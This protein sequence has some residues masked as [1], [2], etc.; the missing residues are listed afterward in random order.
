MTRPNPFRKGGEP[1][2]NRNNELR[3]AS[4]AK[5]KEML[6]SIIAG[7]KGGANPDIPDEAIKR[8]LRPLVGCLA[9]L[10][11]DNPVFETCLD[12]IDAAAQN[13]VENADVSVVI[14]GPAGPSVKVGDETTGP[15][16]CGMTSVQA[17]P[18]VA[19]FIGGIWADM[20][21]DVSNMTH[22]QT[23]G[24]LTNAEAL[25]AANRHAKSLLDGLR[26]QAKTATPKKDGGE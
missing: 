4:M 5:A 23:G 25:G 16:V 15:L 10:V 1:R 22:N 8:M 21:E 18:D 7:V 17:N 11:Y 26:R 6:A 13:A 24:R 20:T 3:E 2:D 9:S 14:F 12:P 19:D